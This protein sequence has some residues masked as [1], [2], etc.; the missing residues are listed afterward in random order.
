MRRLLLIVTFLSCAAAAAAQGPWLHGTVTDAVH[1]RPVHDV[2]VRVEGRPVVVL[3]DRHGVFVLP[4]GSTDRVELELS[5]VAHERMG[6]T[7]Q[8]SPGPDT[9]F[10]RL[11]LVPAVT[12]LPAVTIT[13]PGPEVVHQDPVMHVGDYRVDAD[14]VWVLEYRQAQ[15]WHPQGEAGRQLFREARLVLLDTLFRTVATAPLPG[16]V[17]RLHQDH[18][19]RV[20]VEGV[21]QAWAVKAGPAGIVLDPIAIDVLHGAILPWTGHVPGHL[22]GND[23]TDHWPAFNHFALDTAMDQAHVLHTVTD[24]L[25]MQL[26]RSQYKYMSGRDKVQAMNMG[27]ELGVDPE[28][29]AGYMTGFQHDPYFSVP[30]APLFVLGD[31]IAVFDHADGRMHRF[32][33]DLASL[34]P[35]PMQHHRVRGWRDRLLHDRAHHRVLARYDRN[36]RVRLRPIDISTGELA[37]GHTLAHPY[38]DEVQ[39]HDGHAY[40]LYRPHGS[41]QRRTLYREALR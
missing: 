20:I 19:G 29:V 41:L 31:T 24:A 1:G 12:E 7:V 2:H 6:I 5:H 34:P 8:R 22:I 13:A 27:R 14:G 37:P 4:F 35:V 21:A 40:Y 28:V 23:R 17:R 25:V 36:G 3:T 9:T 18:L 26:F 16:R 30:Y 32:H 39:V 10:V 11:R 38:P 33:T 15:L